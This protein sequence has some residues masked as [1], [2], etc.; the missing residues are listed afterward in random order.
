M[1]R[2]A[3]L[4]LSWLLP[5]LGLPSMP[6]LACMSSNFWCLTSAWSDCR[7]LAQLPGWLVA[8]PSYPHAAH[9]PACLPTWLARLSW[10]Q[11]SKSAVTHKA[12]K[13]ALKQLNESL[14]EELLAEGIKSIAVH[15]LSPGKP[16]SA[17]GQ[18]VLGCWG[19]GTGV[20]N[21]HEQ[22]QLGGQGCALA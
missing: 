11:F 8:R 6:C 22:K 9:L 5:L 14:T 21:T 10:L 15:N 3:G 17:Y 12:T 2:G 1:Q 20:A 13:M 16:R 7:A 19:R 18:L 4:P